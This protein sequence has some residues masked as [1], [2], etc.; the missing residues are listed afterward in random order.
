MV[1]QQSEKDRIEPYFKYRNNIESRL[2]M[3]DF[4]V[5]FEEGD[6]C[7]ITLPDFKADYEIEITARFLLRQSPKWAPKVQ[8][9]TEFLDE[10]RDFHGLFGP[11][12]S[13]R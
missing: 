10:Y 3:L 9:R 2:R 5:L 11:W 12:G 6:E 8:K 1:S 7:S 4:V 13:S